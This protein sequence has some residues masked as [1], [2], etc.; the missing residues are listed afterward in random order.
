MRGLVTFDF[1]EALL[2]VVERRRCVVL[3]IQRVWPGD[4]FLVML[5]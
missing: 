4:A 2:C 3:G 1:A 5:I